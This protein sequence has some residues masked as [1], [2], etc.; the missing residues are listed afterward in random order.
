MNTI[1]TTGT[2]IS[3]WYKLIAEPICVCTKYIDPPNIN[4]AS[5]EAIIELAKERLMNG[6]RMKL[7]LA[8]TNCIVFIMKRFEYIDRRIVLFI[9]T[10]DINSITRAMSDSINDSLLT[11]LFSSSIISF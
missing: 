1:A 6:R 2:I 8:P 5:I 4:S 3:N 9:K 10:I 11:F 7:F